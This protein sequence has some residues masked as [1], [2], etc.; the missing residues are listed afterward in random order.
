M[1]NT[2]VFL[3]RGQTFRKEGEK[4]RRKTGDSDQK[5]FSQI[6]ILLL[7]FFPLD[8]FLLQ[9]R[10]QAKTRMTRISEAGILSFFH[11][12]SITLK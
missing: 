12:L 11:T 10:G 3:Q 2:A 9:A 7:S 8:P 4:R 1:D 6:E 5:S